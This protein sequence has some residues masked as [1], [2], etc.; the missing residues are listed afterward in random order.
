M[1]WQCQGAAA[2]LRQGSQYSSE[3][4]QR[5]LAEQG[6]AC[7]MS[8]RG[9]CWNNVAMESFFS[10]LKIERVVSDTEFS[11]CLA[12]KAQELARGDL[13]WWNIATKTV[14]LYQRALVMAAI[15]R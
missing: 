1:P 4:F 6:I 8:R 5:L 14:S 3:D 13:S 11:H 2:P 7:S 10:T 12:Q 9:D 15:R